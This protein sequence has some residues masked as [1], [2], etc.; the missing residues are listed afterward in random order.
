MRDKSSE[1]AKV[2]LNSAVMKYLVHLNASEVSP[3]VRNRNLQNIVQ[4]FVSAFE[5]NGLQR[6]VAGNKGK[7]I[8]KVLY[9]VIRAGKMLDLRHT[10]EERP[11]VQDEIELEYKDTVA[12]LFKNPNV[13]KDASRVILNEFEKIGV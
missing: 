4:G 12:H 7:T 1:T 8:E 10:P 13:A 6:E 11:P 5:K 9:S 2:H 3:K